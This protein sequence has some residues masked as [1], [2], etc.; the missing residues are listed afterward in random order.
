MSDVD[1]DRLMENGGKASG[2][3]SHRLCPVELESEAGN[4]D[5]GEEELGFNVQE[6]LAEE[7][8]EKEDA[9]KVSDGYIDGKSLVEE[10]DGHIVG[11]GKRSQASNIDIDEE[12]L[13]VNV[14]KS[15]AVESVA[16]KHEQPAPWPTGV[17]T[18]GTRGSDHEEDEE[19][20]GMEK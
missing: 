6:S 2:D 7:V 1:G 3:I 14:Q 20:E 9:A 5:I 19:A 12:V 8:Q 17:T 15:E 10:D 16:T 13:E 11:D 4:G 18:E